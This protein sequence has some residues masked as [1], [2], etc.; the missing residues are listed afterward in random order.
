MM[1]IFAAIIGGVFGM[2]VMVQLFKCLEYD[3][4]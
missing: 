2:I 4:Y 3:G 1:S